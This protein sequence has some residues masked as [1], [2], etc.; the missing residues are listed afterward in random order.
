M[1]TRIQT[2]EE[3]AQKRGPYKPEPCAAGACHAWEWDVR[4]ERHTVPWPE[5]IEKPQPDASPFMLGLSDVEAENERFAQLQDAL[6]PLVGTKVDGGT[7]ARILLLDRSVRTVTL[8]VQKH[9]RGSCQALY[10]RKL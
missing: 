9:E 7:V 6:R 1:N 3:A 4:E 2:P 10:P 5:H 8:V